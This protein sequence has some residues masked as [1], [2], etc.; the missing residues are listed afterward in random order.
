[1]KD[2]HCIRQLI[3]ACSFAFAS[4][5]ASA[6][7][8]AFSSAFAFAFSFAFPSAFAFAFAYTF[9]LSAFI[10]FFHS[11]YPAIAIIVYITNKITV[12]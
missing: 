4:A 6:S 10:T 9:S 7:A 2:W 12:G 3:T 11:K 5:F 8:F 1:L